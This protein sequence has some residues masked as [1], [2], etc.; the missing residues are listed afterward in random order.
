MKKKLLLFLLLCVSFV[1]FAQITPGGGVSKATLPLV[2]SGKTMSIPKATS[3]VNGYLDSADFQAFSGT[4]VNGPVFFAAAATTTS[5]SATYSANTLTLTSPLTVVDSYTI[6][7]GDSLLF[8]NQTAQLQNGLYIYQSSTVLTRC[9]SYDE[10]SEIYPSQIN[11]L[12]GTINATKYFLQTAVDPVVGTDAIVFVSTTTPVST[13]IGNSNLNQTNAN[14]VFQT[15]T[16]NF[17]MTG[18]TGTF[19]FKKANVVIN[20]TTGLSLFGGKLGFYSTPPITKPAAVTTPQGIAD[21]LTSL[22]LLTTSTITASQNIATSNLTSTGTYT[23]GLNS[24]SLTI[25]GGRVSFQ[26]GGSG[27]GTY[28]ATFKN[29]AGTKL[30]TVNDGQ[31]W[32]VGAQEPNV[33]KLGF[34]NTDASVKMIINKQHTESAGHTTIATSTYLHLGGSEYGL[35]TM[36]NLGFGYINANVALAP[37]ALIGYKETDNGGNT[38]GDLLFYTRNVTTDTNPTARYTIKSSGAVNFTPMTATEAS[39][40][41]PAEGDVV[42]VSDTDA[43]FTSIGLWGYQNG[44]WAKM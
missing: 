19:T 38:K 10:T 13:N 1:N 24:N 39:A 14:R 8:K 35:N 33:C 36:R 43:T 4:S 7:V 6:G 44:V 42:M 12:S 20:G 18:T 31:Y 27:S 32:S 37:P 40:I 29:S 22:G 3:S 9:T 5:L 2:I 15:T 41:T 26:G 17:L 21:A 25:G 16:G 28:C 23:L 11:V 34:M 30:M